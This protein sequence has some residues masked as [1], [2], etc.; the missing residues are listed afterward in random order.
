MLIACC[1]LY[2]FP[3]Y[4]SLYFGLTL[5][6][7]CRTFFAVSV[8][9]HVGS[10]RGARDVSS[11]FGWYGTAIAIGQMIGPV[12]AGVTIDGWGTGPTW[13]IMAGLSAMTAIVLPFFIGH[14]KT[15]VSSHPVQGTVRERIKT[16]LSGP[17]FAAILSSS[18]IIFA[19][20][21]RT[22]FFPVFMK[23]LNFSATIIGILISARS[24][25][26]VF[27]RMSVGRVVHI[28][29]GR[30]SAMFACFVL[31]SVGVGSLSLCRTI[32]LLVL[33][34]IVIG[35][36]YGLALTLSQAAV[37]AGAHPSGRAVA[38]GVRLTGNRLAQM[39]SP[40]IFG[41]ITQYFG[42]ATAFWSGGA[43][44]L[45]ASVP[46]FLWWWRRRFHLA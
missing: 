32:P 2:I 35:I 28:L 17:A 26:A 38:L 44:L 40:L 8:Q 29:G 12:L 22:T 37:F 1:Y 7:L 6:M 41:V 13:L 24:F 33:N 23:E 21:T 3:T 27:A 31:L 15:L 18:V 30:F 39:S 19:M 16:L 9:V 36:G 45:C 42:L 20:G 43:V 4:N 25:A 11:N 46:L 14:G 34:S 10:L 5:Y